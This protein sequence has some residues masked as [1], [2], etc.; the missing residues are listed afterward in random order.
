[1]KTSLNE[2]RS[3]S[4]RYLPQKLTLKQPFVVCVNFISTLVRSSLKIIF[5]FRGSTTF[6]LF[7]VNQR[8]FIVQSQS[9]KKKKVS[10]FSFLQWIAKEPNDTSIKHVLFETVGNDDIGKISKTNLSLKSFKNKLF[11]TTCCTEIPLRISRNSYLFFPI[12]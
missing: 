2:Y 3:N 10:I 6:V 4:Y 7:H 11:L 9:C 8:R 1:M 12:K 5:L